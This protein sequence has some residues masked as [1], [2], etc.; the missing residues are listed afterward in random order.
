[1]NILLDNT[2]HLYELFNESDALISDISSVVSDYLKSGK[3]YFVSN[4]A[5]VPDEVFRDL[6]PS[7]GAAYLVGSDL[8]G[9]DEGLAAARGADPMRERRSQVREY[10][11]GDQSVDAMTRFRQAVDAL[12]ARAEHERRRTTRADAE[13]ALGELRE[14]ESESVSQDG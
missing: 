14:S 7:A 2:R 11:I 10:L 5:D 9:L 8:G 3:P 1:M 6:N 4:L 13:A 12:A